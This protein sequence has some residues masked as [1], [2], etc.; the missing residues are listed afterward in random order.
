MVTHGSTALI[1]LG[2]ES[3]R[4]AILNE[5]TNRGFDAAS[6]ESGQ[7]G[8]AIKRAAS[9]QHV[10][11]DCVVMNSRS[12]LLSSRCLAKPETV[13]YPSSASIPTWKQLRCLPA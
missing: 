2:N 8:M 5:A 11:I 9:Q 6:A 10:P 12:L 3:R 13:R 7:Q 1:V 4:A